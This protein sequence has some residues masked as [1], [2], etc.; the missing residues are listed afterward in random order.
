MSLVATLAEELRAGAW[1]AVAERADVP[2]PDDPTGRIAALGSRALGRL[3]FPDACLTFAERA[4]RR[5][6]GALHTLASAEAQLATGQPGRARATLESLLDDPGPLSRPGDPSLHELQMA[7]CDLL[8]ACGESARAYGLALKVRAQADRTSALVDEEAWMTLGWTA[9]AC[10]RGQEAARAFGH[11]HH[12]RTKRAAEDTL[13]AQS[14]D[15]LGACARVLGDPHQA[16]A[17]HERALSLWARA[18]GPGSPSVAACRHR[19]AHALHRSGDFHRARDAMAEAMLATAKH[20]G[21]DHVDTWIS[22]F[23][24]ARYDIDCGDFTDGFARMARAR[25]EVAKRLGAQ[26]P[27][28]RSMDRYL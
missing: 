26:H 4:A 21:R 7:L 24:V 3:G 11:A 12:S 9:W 1:R 15:G 23:E 17:Y 14:L 5:G 28:V 20:F 22:R 27:V 6:E 10:G 8:R 25:A 19:L 18:T 16:I 13:Q 2:D